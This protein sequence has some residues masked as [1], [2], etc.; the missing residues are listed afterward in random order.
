[1]FLLPVYEWSS[2]PRSTQNNALQIFDGHTVS[3]LRNE[4]EV[5]IGA[6]PKLKIS[7]HHRN[8]WFRVEVAFPAELDEAFGVA[9]NKQGVRLKEHTADAILEA[10]DG[11]FGRVVA[12]MKAVIGQRKSE[13]AAAAR[14]G[15]VG[16]A[17]RPAGEA[18]TLQAVA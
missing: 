8:D 7:K 16:D 11:R 12:E 4:R 6:E 15:Q 14:A 18:D 9:A 17:E 3:Y 5:D 10:S 2:L 13:S 1:M